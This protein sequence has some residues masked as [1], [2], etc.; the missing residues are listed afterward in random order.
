MFVDAR[1]LPDGHVV[2]A[3]LCIVGAGAVGIAMALQFDGGNARVAVLESGGY[4]LD[5]ETQSLYEGSHVG[6]LTYPLETN[7][8]RYFGGTT[9][10][11]AGHCRPFD[12]F[13]FSTREWIPHSGWPI[14]IEELDPYLA[15]TQTVLELGKYRYDELENYARQ[16]KLPTLPL[17]SNRLISV[18]KHQSTPTRFGTVYRPALEKSRNVSVY[19]YS[20]ILELIS[21]E[22]ASR[23]NS[24]EV[25]CIDGPR[26]KV[27]ARHFV[28]ATGGLENPRL[29]LL[30]NRTA[31]EGLGNDN[32]LVGRFYT[33][34]LLIRPAMDI[35]L[36]RTDLD[37]RLYT[38]K[39]DINGGLIF[40]I[41]TPPAELTRRERLTRFRFH[42]YNVGPRYGSPVGGVFS[43]LDGAPEPAPLTKEP[44]TYIQVHMAM[45]PIPNPDAFVR[46]G[47]DLD[48]F[49]QRKLECKW[50]VTEQELANAR[51]A[52]EIGALEF[53]RM[54]FGRAHAQIL[55]RPDEWPDAFTSGKH[56]C[57]T[58]RMA[59]NPKQ[60]VVDRN[61][62]VF[63]I[64]NLFVTGSSIFPN[65]G[66]TNP[67]LNLIALSLRLAD[68]IKGRL[69]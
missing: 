47:D 42:L 37:F 5:H 31:A 18:M 60:G 35:S 59:D 11:W 40:G 56:H 66:H 24:A 36:S 17:D 39:H 69:A 22:T 43:D 6:R 14:T 27:R 67:T 41:M 23:I 65:I 64:D 20:N 46:L 63:G 54:G 68:H 16:L 44:G 10:H 25:A 57:G 2:D 49:G 33:D 12:A 29:M 55:D 62:K 28:L 32:G 3:D 58:T 48:R 45:E 38:D 7:R 21:N 1:E 34:H 4:K 50:L 13:D 52:I 8:L 61:C 30:S 15:E 53:A 9:G 51:R 26:Y 19:L